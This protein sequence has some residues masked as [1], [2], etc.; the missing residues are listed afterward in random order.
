MD[1]VFYIS[2][3]V[4]VVTSFFA[5][6]LYFFF[7]I[8]DSFIKLKMLKSIH[9]EQSAVSSQADDATTGSFGETLLLSGTE[10]LTDTVDETAEEPNKAEKVRP[11]TY[12]S[13]RNTDMDRVNKI[14]N[15]P[16]PNTEVISTSALDA[17]LDRM[18]HEAG[19]ASNDATDIMLDIDGTNQTSQVNTRDQ[20][21][22]MSNLFEEETES[23]A[24]LVEDRHTEKPSDNQDKPAS[25]DHMEIMF[26]PDEADTDGTADK[27][28]QTEIMSMLDETDTDVMSDAGDQTEIMSDLFVSK[29]DNDDDFDSQEFDADAGRSAVDDKTEIMFDDDEDRKAVS[30]VGKDKTEIMSDLFEEETDRGTN[31]SEDHHVEEPSN[32]KTEI[33]FMPDED[34]TDSAFA[35]DDQTQIMSDLFVSQ[36]DNDDDSDKQEFDANAERLVVDDNT[37]IM[38]DGDEDRN[39]VSVDKTDQTEIMSMPYEADTDATVDAD[40]QTEI[41]PD[42]FVDDDDNNSTA[43]VSDHTAIFEEEEDRDADDRTQQSMADTINALSDDTTEIMSSLFE[44]DKDVTDFDH[45]KTTIVSADDQ[46]DILVKGL[47]EMEQSIQENNADIEDLTGIMS[48][49]F[50]SDDKRKF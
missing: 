43:D 17:Y 18:D 8:K 27:G 31:L 20:T 42:L 4:C 28:D 11:S 23:D 12:A 50:K 19:A 3:I 6:L 5:V 37:E 1:I 21:E 24:D 49:L 16:N 46:T 41:M 26:M 29:T 47:Q 45:N 40:D 15:S 25:N 34:N 44:E 35:T 10:L 7:N 13:D 48:D 9:F 30:A 32:G 2:I 14:F 33:M 22:I 38:F 39:A 36:T